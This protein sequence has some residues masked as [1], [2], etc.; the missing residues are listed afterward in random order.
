MD[1]THTTNYENSPINNPSDNMISSND[2]NNSES[3]IVLKSEEIED[4]TTLTN[5][6]IVI[7]PISINS[8]SPLIKEEDHDPMS[9]FSRSNNLI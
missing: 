3:N 2:Q 9:A 5:K 1:N 8:T 7:N 4:Y 6:S